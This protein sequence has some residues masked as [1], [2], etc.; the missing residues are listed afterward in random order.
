MLLNKVTK[1]NL[2]RVELNLNPERV[3]FRSRKLS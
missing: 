2:E 1:P 3:E